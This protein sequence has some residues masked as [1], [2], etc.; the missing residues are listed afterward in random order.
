MLAAEAGRQAEDLA[1]GWLQERGFVIRRRNWRTRWC[2]LDII[3]ERKGVIHIVE[4]KYRRRPDFGSGFEA[5]T[6][7]KIRRLQRAALM[8][9]SQQGSHDRDYQID[10]M[11]VSGLPKPKTVEYL[12]NA[13]SAE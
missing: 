9:L 6:P 8:W 12:P 11:A 3:A 5:I 13:I 1:A 7:D 10:I 2:E 4:V